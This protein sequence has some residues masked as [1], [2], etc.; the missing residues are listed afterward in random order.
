MLQA[1]V[2]AA[3]FIGRAD[4]RFGEQE[5]EVFIDSMREVVAAA[6][7][8]DFLDEL[9]ST[10][11]LLDQVRAARSALN[12]DG[13]GVFLEKLAQRFH[14]E[15]SRDGLVLAYRLV[16]ADGKV[17]EAEANAF[18]QLADALGLEVA[19]IEALQA[20]AA[21]WKVGGGA[22]LRDAHVARFSAMQTHG[23]HRFQADGFDLGLEYVQRE[24][25]RVRLELDGRQTVLHVHVLDGAGAGPRMVCLYG[26]ALDA[27]LAVLDALKDTLTTATFQSKLP[28]IRAV[29]PELFVEQ[30]GR[31]TH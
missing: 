12:R 29:S 10:P 21:Q 2:E 11:K 25:G 20:L 14:G 27:L 7:G 22:A 5:L 23:W 28:A 24:G 26:E 13:R 31:F 4:G 18:A 16:L 3:V 8:D 17:T 15:F 9:V 19:E 1:L 30:N 6:V